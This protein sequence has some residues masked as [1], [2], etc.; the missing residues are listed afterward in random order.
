MLYALA[1][2]DTP[3]TPR[4]NGR[5]T[6]EQDRATDAKVIRKQLRRSLIRCVATA[7]AALWLWPRDASAH[8]ESARGVGGVGV[9][10]TGGE[11]T[12]GS[13]IY[14]RYDLR[15]YS[16]FSD[17]ELRRYQAGGE[18]VHQHRREHTVFLGST[19]DIA[20]R[21]DLT[22]LL[23]G[24]RFDG[25]TDNG[26][27]YA[28][29]N[30]TLSR[31]TTS[32]GIG[33][34]L[35]LARYQLVDASGHH[36][37]LIN[38]LKLPTGDIRQRTNEGN[39]VGTHNQPGSGSVD[40]QIGAGY[41]T[42]PTRELLLSADAIVRINSEGAGSFRSGNSLQ[43]DVAAGFRLASFLVPSV[44]LNAF[45]QERD[46][47]QDAVK[48]NSGVYSL[49]VTPA[50]RVTVG[51]HS[52]FV[53]GSAP[54]LQTF[55]GLSNPERFRGSVGYAFTLGGDHDHHPPASPPAVPLQP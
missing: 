20:P 54:L 38:G 1:L 22:I 51:A 43:A 30:K 15:S 35:L 24:N 10:T 3:S 17:D 45:F 53:A 46:I 13:A 27:S 4:G 28:L 36:I 47:E 26:D 16:L 42:H 8:G 11:V 49:F 29:A 55:P 40:L 23:Q 21:W 14:A 44:E 48:K 25:F 50:V 2:R 31:T 37:A 5:S 18:N 52:L 19:F 41:T 34:L 7:A 9:N 33:D 6:N 39:I 32:Q 12:S